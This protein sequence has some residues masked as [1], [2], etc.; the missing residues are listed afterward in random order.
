VI[1]GFDIMAIGYAA[2]ALIKDW[3]INGA[4]LGPVF[5]SALFGVLLGSLGWSMLADRVGRRPVLIAATFFFAAMTLWTARTMSVGELIAARFVAGI[6]LGGIMPNVVALIG[7]L[8]PARNRV[9]TMM[10]VGNGMNIGSVLGGGVAAWIIPHYGWRSVFYF[11]GVTPIIVGL[12][13]V[14]WLPE[15]PQ[16]LAAQ[17]GNG[18]R[19]V[20]KGGAAF[21]LFREGR[22]FTT[23]L[24]WGLFFI[25]LL[26][27]YL[28][29]SWLPTVMSQIG[30]TTTT[31]VLIGTTLQIGGTLASFVMAAFVGSLG[32]AGVLL[33]GFAIGA[34]SIGMIGLTSHSLP[35]LFTVV[36]LAG[37]GVVGNQGTLNAFA[38]TYYPTFLRSTGV[39]WCLGIG[40]LGAIAGP[41]FAGEIMKRNIPPTQLFGVV[42]VLALIATSNAVLLRR[43]AQAGGPDCD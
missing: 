34:A 16:L 3:H 9:A 8:S 28:L 43:R 24:L 25:N 12:A 23:F 17:K 31:A 22:A 4:A 10:V 2:P 6:G 21:E 18:K 42:A 29:S 36:F 11:G 30:Y 37:W 20:R 5:S 14:C 26:N 33:I 41:L 27:L 7:E 15:S 32:T 19:V 13:M 1:D 40:R 35:L 38:A 39:G